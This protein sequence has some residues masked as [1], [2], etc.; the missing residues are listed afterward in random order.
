M[1]AK[2]G[3]LREMPRVQSLGEVLITPRTVSRGLY[4]RIQAKLKRSWCSRRIDQMVRDLKASGVVASVN[5]FRGTFEMPLS[6]NMVKRILQGCYETTQ[7]RILEAI[8]RDGDHV[9][10]VGANLGLFSV[11]S[12]AIVGSEGGVLAIEPVPKMVSCL[13]GNIRRNG[14]NNVIVFDGVASDTL[15]ECTIHTAEGAEEYSSIKKI[16]HPHGQR[17]NERIVKVKS[18]TLDTLVTTH[19][20]SPSVVKVDVEG[21]EGLV[22]S[23]AHVVLDR[24]RPIVLSELD[25]RLL[26]GFG[27]HSGRVVEFLSGHGYFVFDQNTKRPLSE[28]LSGFVGDVIAIPM[29]CRQD[30]GW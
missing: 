29:E 8:L 5:A 7:V 1:N 15:D 12:A 6:N 25:D 20:L 13:Q 22:F 21:A 11:L 28:S 17:D 30:L 19:N 27:W 18:S 10:D 26:S 4:S 23:G 9:I 14:L 24:F 3:D 16:A 2:N